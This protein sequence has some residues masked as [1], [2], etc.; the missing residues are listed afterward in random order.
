MVWDYV[1]AVA[2]QWQNLLGVVLLLMQLLPALIPFSDPMI[3]RLGSRA[4]TGWIVLVF[5][6]IA[7]YT[8]F[9][10]D[11]HDISVLKSTNG[12]DW[13]ALPKSPNAL[14]HGQIWNN[15]GVPVIVQD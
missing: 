10:Q 15:G 1:L 14:R 13:S 3:K 8:V 6:V 7:N 9:A 11:Q 4:A 5:F 2:W 12:I